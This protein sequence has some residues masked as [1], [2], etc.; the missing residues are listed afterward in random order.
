MNIQNSHIFNAKTNSQKEKLRK[1]ISSKRVK[2][3][4]I[5]LRKQKSFT[6]KKKRKTQTKEIEDDRN[7]YT[8]IYCVVCKN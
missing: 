5:N 2:Y 1:N 4:G 8:V 6:Q 3:L 7:K